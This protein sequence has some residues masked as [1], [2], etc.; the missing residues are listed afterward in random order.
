M[1]YDRMA[2]I[3]YLFD[4]CVSF[5]SIILFTFCP[6][7]TIVQKGKEERVTFS[8]CVYLHQKFPIA[9]SYDAHQFIQF[10]PNNIR[11]RFDPFCNF[12]CISMG[13]EERE[14]EKKTNDNE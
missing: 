9:V 6:K 1:E 2:I 8:F 4:M 14:E 11:N 10:S 5:E 12:L 7:I 3:L 13:D